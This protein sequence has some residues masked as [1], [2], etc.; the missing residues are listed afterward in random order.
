MSLRL[1]LTSFG[2][3]GDVHPYIALAHGLKARGHRPILATSEFH[4]GAIT[5]EGLEFHPVRPNGD[6]ND[7]ELMRRIMD[8]RRGPEVVL[9]EIIAPAIRESYEDLSAAVRGADLLVTHPIAFAG[10]LVGEKLGLPWV[11][12]VLAPLSFFSRYDLPVFPG[13]EAVARLRALGPGVA[14][15]L[16][17]IAKHT[18]RRWA[19]P[20]RQLRADLGLPPGGD[21]IYEGQF[22]PRL[23]LGLFSR[24]LAEPRPDWPPN[25]RVTGH[26]FYD[27]GAGRLDPA[28][29]RFLDHGPPPIVFTLGS[30]AVMT[31]GDFFA[32]SAEAA[33]RLGRRA[34]LLVGGSP[35]SRP[36]EPMPDGMIAVEYAPHSLVFPRAA[37]IVHQAGI[38]T[39]GQALRA[40]R[41]SLLVPFSHDQPDNADRITRLGIARTLYPWRYRVDRV[42]RE[43]KTLLEDDGY[44]KRAGEVGRIVQSER[45]VEAACEAIEQ[46]AGE[47]VA[48][49]QG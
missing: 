16:I 15:L 30:S 34:V 12:T 17:R 49:R 46:A 8:R 10:P 14:G 33:R 5:R 4:R 36:R 41:P 27:G 39:A 6:A 7:V 23:T 31:A 2:S 40:G 37:A 32:V 38:G 35:A 29:A 9:K 22:S 13:M 11:S 48:T 21:P 19:D 43:L 1:V 45:G 47:R 24:V 44:A 20:V 25:T 42:A 26:L 18:T 3:L 28:L